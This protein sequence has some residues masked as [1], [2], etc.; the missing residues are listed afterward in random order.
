MM[1]DGMRK[2]F[3]VAGLMVAAGCSLLMGALRLAEGL[4]DDESWRIAL[5]AFLLLAG[6]FCVYQAR[7]LHRDG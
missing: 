6:L 7:Q 5:G 1:D 3:A 4:A 2:G